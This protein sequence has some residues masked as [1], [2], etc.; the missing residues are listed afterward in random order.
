M[1]NNSSTGGYLSPTSTGGDLNDQALA[2]FLQQIV[3]NITG[4][5]GA[6]VR[7]RWQAEPPN[8]PDFGTNWAA[9][10]PGV[11]KRDRYPYLQQNA[12]GNGSTIVIKNRVMD[13]LA[14]FYGPAAEQNAEYL[15]MGLDV[16]QNRE[17]MQL[18]GFNIIGGAG[19][20]IVVPRLIKQ[21]WQYAV[22]IPFTVR[23]QLQYTFSVENL[24]GAAGTLIADDQGRDITETLT[25]NPPA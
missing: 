24:D 22:D 7:P 16:P 12:S 4:L 11:R 10:G 3:V 19:D 17:L 18:A 6:M 15:A 13:I 2:K 20:S 21:R 25:V 5:P 8:I 1:P 23:Q 14:T 9:I